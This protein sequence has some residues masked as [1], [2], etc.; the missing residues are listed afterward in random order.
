MKTKKE[1]VKKKNLNIKFYYKEIEV[2]LHLNKT[3]QLNRTNAVIA[4][5]NTMTNNKTVVPYNVKINLYLLDNYFWSEEID[6]FICRVHTMIIHEMTHYLFHTYAPIKWGYTAPGDISSEIKDIDE[7]MA[8]FNEKCL[9]KI[10]LYSN[11]IFKL[12]KKETSKIIKA[13]QIHNKKNKTK[14]KKN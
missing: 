1:K 4:S 13:K 9:L 12:V 3:K 7:E 5:S 11:D 6:L 8:L 10:N 2:I 14:V